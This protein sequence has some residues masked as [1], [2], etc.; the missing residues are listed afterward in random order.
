MNPCLRSSQKSCQTLIS[1]VSPSGGLKWSSPPPFLSAS[2]PRELQ[3][4]SQPHLLPP[5]VLHSSISKSLPYPTHGL[6]VHP[7]MQAGGPQA[8]CSFGK[9]ALPSG[10]GTLLAEHGEG[11][12]GSV[13]SCLP[14]AARSSG[15]GHSH[16]IRSSDPGVLIPWLHLIPGVPSLCGEKPMRRWAVSCVS[17]CVCCPRRTLPGAGSRAQ[18]LL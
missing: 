6:R 14:R 1:L 5:R 11:Q 18:F 15:Q 8:A 4:R 10:D 2:S 17:V 12:R 7:P 3:T 9:A 13:T 16:G